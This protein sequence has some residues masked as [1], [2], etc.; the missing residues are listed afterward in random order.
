MTFKVNHF[1]PAKKA[2]KVEFRAPRFKNFTFI[3]R[4]RLKYIKRYHNK[5]C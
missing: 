2:S 4:L 3:S 5:I 1:A